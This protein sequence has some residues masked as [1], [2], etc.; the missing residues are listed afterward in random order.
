MPRMNLTPR[1]RELVE[2]FR[3]ERNIYNGALLDVVAALTINGPC[4]EY[5]QGDPAAE[6][7]VKTILAL[8]KED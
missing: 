3:T 4:S 7:I 5:A 8:R 2:A 6:E 1:E